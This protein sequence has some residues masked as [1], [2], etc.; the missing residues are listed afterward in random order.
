VHPVFGSEVGEGFLEVAR[1]EWRQAFGAGV[2]IVDAELAGRRHGRIELRAGVNGGNGEMPRGENRFE[3][4][5]SPG[6][7]GAFDPEAADGLS[8][9]GAFVTKAER[10]VAKGGVKGERVRNFN[11]HENVVQRGDSGINLEA[12]PE[13]G[14]TSEQKKI[15]LLV[16]ACHHR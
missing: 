12:R 11:A 13:D 5:Q 9:S 6:D 10:V 14:K 2:G 15:S 1:G 7:F 3:V 4:A 16:A 8:A